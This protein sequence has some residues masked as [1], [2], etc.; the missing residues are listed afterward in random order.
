[1]L[2]KDILT[3]I[4]IV[5]LL[6]F[7]PLSFGSFQRPDNEMF[8]DLPGG[9]KM[10]Q[11]GLGMC[12]RATAYDDVL[13]YRSVLWYLLLGGRHIDGAHLYLN[14]K[15]IGEA[16]AEAI[17]RGVKREEIFVTTKIF[18]TQF[19]YES[20]LEMVNKYVEELGLDYIDL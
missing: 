10:P 8:L 18:P 7:T 3:L 15:A 17:R 11:E 9:F 4:L 20:S 5:Y 6:L 16:L 14:H 12:C 13:V 1:M 2:K 19:G